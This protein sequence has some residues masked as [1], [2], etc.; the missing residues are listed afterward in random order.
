MQAGTAGADIVYEVSGSAGSSVMRT[1][2]PRC[3]GRIVVVAIFL[4]LRRSKLKDTGDKGLDQ[5]EG[6]QGGITLILDTLRQD[7]RR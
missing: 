6:Y 3:R 5:P 1:T 7:N 2:L 4:S